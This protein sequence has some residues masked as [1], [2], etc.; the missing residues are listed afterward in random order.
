MIPLSALST[1]ARIRMF[2]LGAEASFTESK[3]IEADRALPISPESPAE[4]PT[5]LDENLTSTSDAKR[6]RA[7]CRSSTSVQR[8]DKM[9]AALIVG[10]RKRKW[11][12][13]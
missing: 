4:A 9:A 8:P 1:M 12:Q 2:V 11:S 10:P 7:A 13:G 3:F 6:S 5:L